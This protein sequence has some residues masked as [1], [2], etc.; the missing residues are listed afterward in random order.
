MPRRN[1]RRLRRAEANQLPGANGQPTCAAA[2]DQELV[3]AVFSQINQRLQDKQDDNADMVR[4]ME[5]FKENRKVLRRAKQMGA[6]AT[7][8]IGL[9]VERTCCVIV[10][11]CG[12]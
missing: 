8:T 9:G 12:E 11:G 2:Y 1:R 6:E 3:R 4:A 10:D 7:R 5:H